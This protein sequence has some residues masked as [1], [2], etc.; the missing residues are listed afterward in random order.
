MPSVHPPAPPYPFTPQPYPFKQRGARRQ[1]SYARRTPDAASASPSPAALWSLHRLWRAGLSRRPRRPRVGR[2]RQVGPAK[3]AAGPAR[4]RQLL[5]RLTLLAPPPPDTASS[6]AQQRGAPR[7]AFPRCIFGPQVRRPKVWLFSSLHLP[8]L[9]PLLLVLV[10]N[11]LVLFCC[12]F[13][14]VISL[15]R[16]MKCREVSGRCPETR[17]G[18]SPP[19]PPFA[20]NA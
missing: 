12:Y 9:N 20:Y 19:R 16:L 10:S 14:I 8:S 1:P 11:G 17:E 15:M 6:D 7:S 3:A 4:R 18:A 5:H 13:F 2:V